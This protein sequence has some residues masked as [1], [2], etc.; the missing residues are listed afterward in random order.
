MEGLPALRR[1][2]NTVTNGMRPKYL[3]YNIWDPDSDF[4]PNTADWT[5]TAKPLEGPPQ[6]AL[7]DET[8][9]KTINENPYLF[10]IVTPINV[11]VFEAYLV[12]HPNQAFVKSVCNGFREGFWPWAETP[13]PGYPETNDESKP[14]PTDV[15]K[16]EFLRAQRDIE[17]IKDRFSPPFTHGLL[18][19]MYCM[20]IYAVPKPH[21]TDLRL[22]T[23]QSYGK[24]SLNS[25]IN[26]DKVTGYPLDNMVHFGEM[27][28]DLE[29]RDPGS[30]KVV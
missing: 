12:S 6:T 2:T 8:V 14:A 16:A 11:D 27:L 25:M 15:K 29:R 10:K 30:E 26:H 23:D 9:T 3:R 22:V 18:P 13:K 24:Y 28:M 17:L 4:S 7:D 5:L 21:S 1:K 20:P 19:G